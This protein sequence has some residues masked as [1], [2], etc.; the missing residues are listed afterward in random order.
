MAWKNYPKKRVHRWEKQPSAAPVIPV[1]SE[2]PQTDAN[3]NGYPDAYEAQ[4]ASLLQQ[5][6][7]RRKAYGYKKEISA[8]SGIGAS[9]TQGNSE[10]IESQTL[11]DIMR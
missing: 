3:G 8:Y 2:V 9:G 4:E 5:I 11:R 6:A 7:N 1:Q 10:D